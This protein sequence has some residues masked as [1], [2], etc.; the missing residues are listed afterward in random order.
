LTP[1]KGDSSN[2]NN[3]ISL[4]LIFLVIQ[5]NNT[6]NKIKPRLGNQNGKVTHVALE[7]I[8]V[9]IKNIRKIFLLERRYSLREKI[10]KHVIM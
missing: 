5:S 1:K 7:R 10:I 3:N 9:T 2:Q 8:K 6:Y 4:K